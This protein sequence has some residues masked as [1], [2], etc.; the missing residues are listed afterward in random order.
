MRL[1]TETS[2]FELKVLGY[3]FPSNATDIDDS[4]WLIIEGTGSHLGKQWNFRDPCLLTWEVSALAKYF[5]SIATGCTASSDMSFI[6]P[7]LEFAVVT[8]SILRVTFSLEAE[9]PWFE[10]NPDQGDNFFLEFE[11]KPQQLREASASLRH[12]LLS[13]PGRAGAA[14]TKNAV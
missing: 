11:I 6:E 8:S 9:P 14:T 1:Q 2:S 13:F 5:E 7:N 12:Q 4:N 3:Q 10:K